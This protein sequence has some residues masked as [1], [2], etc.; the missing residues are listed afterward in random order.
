MKPRDF[1]ALVVLFLPCALRDSLTTQ[2][3]RT[4]WSDLITEFV[5]LWLATDF[6]TSFVVTLVRASKGDEKIREA[7]LRYAKRDSRVGGVVRRWLS[8][9]T[10]DV[11][12]V[13]QEAAQHYEYAWNLY[14]WRCGRKWCKDLKS[15]YKQQT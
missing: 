5:D 12:Y 4:R 6:L 9:E 3:A 7:L 8:G 2:K 11:Y 15:R 14:C 1:Y 10:V 13:L